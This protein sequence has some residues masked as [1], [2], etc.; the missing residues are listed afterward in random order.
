[1]GKKEEKS[2]CL[3]LEGKRSPFAP[4]V[5]LESLEGPK[6]RKGFD[7]W[8]CS[9]CVRHNLE[10]AL[11]GVY[12]KKCLQRQMSVYKVRV[13]TKTNSM[14][15]S[16]YD[17]IQFTLVTFEYDAGKLAQGKLVSSAVRVSSAI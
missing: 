17:S 7:G 8:A 6:V 10:I 16:L 15:E 4:T 14:T 12:T 9:E 5:F 1:M 11:F 2:R 3:L 13:F